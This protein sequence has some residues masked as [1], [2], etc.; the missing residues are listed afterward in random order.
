MIAQLCS[1]ACLR[2]TTTKYQ[3][4]S[5]NRGEQYWRIVRASAL[6]TNFTRGW[7]KAEKPSSNVRPKCSP[8][9]ERIEKERSTAHVQQH[10]R[11]RRISF[12]LQA[13]QGHEYG[14]VESRLERQGFTEIDSQARRSH[15]SFINNLG[16]TMGSVYC[17]SWCGRIPFCLKA[18]TSGLA[19]SSFAN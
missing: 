3:K 12:Q 10:R 15:N 4:K 2:A 19:S 16:W 17:S 1:C 6:P 5:K 14:V 8:P 9:L 13:I 11:T 18:S 7:W